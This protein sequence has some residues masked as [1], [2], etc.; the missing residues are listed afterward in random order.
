MLAVMSNWVT[1]D[2]FL[3]STPSIPT[4][5][6]NHA[7]PAFDATFYAIT[8]G[9]IAVLVVVVAWRSVT[10]HAGMALRARPRPANPRPAGSPPPGP[11]ASC[12]ASTRTLNSARSSATRPFADPVETRAHSASRNAVTSAP[13]KS[14]TDTGPPGL[15][16]RP[17]KRRAARRT[18]APTLR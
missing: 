3:S 17:R 16:R 13:D 4:L 11:A 8:A 6:N 1:P 9:V 15:T 5:A 14:A 18:G 2:G 10:R 12:R 7:G